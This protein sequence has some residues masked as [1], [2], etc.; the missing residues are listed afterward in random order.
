MRF[1]DYGNTQETIGEDLRRVELSLFAMP[2]LAK[3]CILEGA[4]ARNR[5]WFAFSAFFEQMVQDATMF[6]MIRGTLS[7]TQTP[8]YLVDLYTDSEMHEKFVE[9]LVR[10]VLFIF[11]P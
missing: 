2:M 11:G 10:N 9:R 4:I 8:V 6:G 5:D 1:V 3:E 7:H